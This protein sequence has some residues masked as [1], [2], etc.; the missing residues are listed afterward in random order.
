MIKVK[1]KKLHPNAK[2]PKK[3]HKT[4]G[5][6]DLFA[7]SAKPTTEIVNI[8]SR[9]E[10]T[11]V[12]YWEYDTMLSIEIPVNHVGLIFPRSSIS[13]TSL[14]LSNCVGLIDENYRGTIKFRF[15]DLNNG[16]NR[17]NVGD[18]IGQLLIL[19]YPEVEWEEATDLSVSERGADGF[20]SSGK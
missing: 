16:Q 8:R 9:N 12:K 1:F 7:V 6:F 2:M 19:P 5:A 14:V 17:Y 4:D 11:I 15:R 20:G 13:E 10:N 18:R 3:A